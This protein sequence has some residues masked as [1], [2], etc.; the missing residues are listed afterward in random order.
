M[1]SSKLVPARLAP[2]RLAS[3]RLAPAK[4]ASWRL[5][6]IR[7]ASRWLAEVRSALWRLAEVSVAPLREGVIHGWS[8]LHW[9]QV[10]M[11]SR[12]FSPRYWLA[13]PFL[14]FGVHVT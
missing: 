4:L 14:P 11:P 7:L 1:A 12:S 5:A 3:R 8:C 13:I 9:F 10:S 2:A 6:L